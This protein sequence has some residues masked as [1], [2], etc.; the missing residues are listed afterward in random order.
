MKGAN[1]SKLLDALRAKPLDRALHSRGNDA[2]CTTL[3]MT[4]NAVK[5]SE[6]DTETVGSLGRCV[7]E[8]RKQYARIRHVLFTIDS[9]IYSAVGRP[10]NAQP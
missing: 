1:E 6:C 9:N 4:F 7:L 8:N 2:P 5:V 10:R 3:H